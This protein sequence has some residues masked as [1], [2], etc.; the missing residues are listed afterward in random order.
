MK[1]IITSVLM[2]LLIT[3]VYAVYAET[4]IEH[5]LDTVKLHTCS[6]LATTTGNTLGNCT[7]S[8]SVNRPI[9]YSSNPILPSSSFTW[10]YDTW[11]VAI[12][13]Y[14]Y[15]GESGIGMWYLTSDI[16]SSGLFTNFATITNAT[17]LTRYLDLELISY[18]GSIHDN[19][20]IAKGVV[21]N[22][23]GSLPAGI[24][25]CPL[26]YSSYNY[27]GA[28]GYN[29]GGWNYQIWA[30]VDGFTNWTVINTV[31]H[32]VEWD[33]G[34][35]FYRDYDN[36][37]IVHTQ[38]FD[39]NNYRGMGADVFGSDLSSVPNHIDNLLA[40]NGITDQVYNG[41]TGKH[42]ELYYSFINTFNKSTE[43]MPNIRLYVSRDGLPTST[44]LKDSAWV[45]AGTTGQWDYAMIGG[46]GSLYKLNNKWNF[47]YWG[48][49]Q[50]H[51]GAGSGP[52][53]IGLAQVDYQRIGQVSGTGNI[54][55]TS[56]VNPTGYLYVNANGTGGTIKAE[57]LDT[58]DNVITGYSQ[59]E[60]NIVSTDTY[61]A[62]ITWD[63]NHIPQNQT[64]KI[65]FYLADAVLYSFELRETGV[66]TFGSGGGVANLGS[67]GKINL[68]Q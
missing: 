9:K 21:P 44:N 40:P 2:V 20:I 54:V 67:G 55:S 35:I 29:Y 42:G 17:T 6:E 43:R 57:L 5:F 1:N 7:T 16:A 23:Y 63:G 30:S 39:V 47:Y 10:D 26:C 32:S 13:P 28:S 25:Y 38:Y 34:A 37:W 52:S 27:F 14:S 59:N 36:T 45:S 60:S 18:G 11:N 50:Y 64:V 65:K 56:I 41:M 31:T 12:A 62:E 61:S 58:N 46:P 48:T 15:G 53:Q 33:P 24:Q 22:G 19:N 49:Q 66:V 51:N 4:R 3:P 68:A 8:G